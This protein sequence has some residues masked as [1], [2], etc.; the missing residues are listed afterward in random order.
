MEEAGKEAKI[1]RKIRLASFTANPKTIA[2]FED[3]TL[4][5]KIVV[6]AEAASVPGLRFTFGRDTVDREGS[7]LVSPLQTGA[8]QLKVHGELTSRILGDVVVTVVVDSCQQLEIRSLQLRPQ[9][10]K[11]RDRFLAGSLTPRGE[12]SVTSSSDGLRIKVPL[13]IAIENFFDADADVTLTLIFPVRA[14]RV[15]VTLVDVD[16]DV[17]FGLGEHIASL[18]SATFL[19]AAMQPLAE[20]LITAFLGAQ[21]Q[22]DL[23]GEINLIVNPL[24]QLWQN[25][26]PRK[27]KFKLYSITTT[28]AGLTFMGCPDA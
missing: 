18:G 7:R 21:L 4:A 23:S 12:V 20:D 17:I 24:L 19:Q 15:D 3:S 10:E 25:A 8:F 27:R 14:G 9:A 13:E 11:L 16:V 2:P 26:D 5:W 28:N 22:G 6:P 1:L